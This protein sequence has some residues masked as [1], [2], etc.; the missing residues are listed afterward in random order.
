MKEPNIFDLPLGSTP[1][2]FAYRVHT[3]IGHKCRGAKINGRVVPLNTTLTSGDRIEVIVGDDPEP[4]RDWLHEHLG[5]VSTSRARAK[6][7]GWFAR[8]ER[9]KNFDEGKKLLLDELKLEI[10]DIDV[11]LS[12]A[13]MFILTVS[14]I[15]L[16]KSI[17]SIS[18][19]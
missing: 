8:R 4:R 12:I 14:I 16:R 1:V 17:H 18:R 15:D 11:L 7:Q 6:I 5:Y 2:D 19:G 10:D 3:E 13:V 9:Q